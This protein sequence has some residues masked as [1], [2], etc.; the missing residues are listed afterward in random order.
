MLLLCYLL[1]EDYQ[2]VGKF[3][4]VDQNAIEDGEELYSNIIS[5]VVLGL[6]LISILTQFFLKN[7]YTKK[8]LEIL[9]K[10]VNGIYGIFLILVG[11]TFTLMLLENLGNNPMNGIKDIAFLSL[12]FIVFI[13]FTYLGILIL[14]QLAKRE[15]PRE[16][17]DLENIIDSEIK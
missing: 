16:N 11:V 5:V 6:G 7:L 10:V 3:Q 2:R 14:L 8:L 12:M 4:W 1:Y 9:L 15:L 17:V 13:S